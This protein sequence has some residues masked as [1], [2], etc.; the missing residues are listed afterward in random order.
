MRRFVFAFLSLLTM[1]GISSGAAFAQTGNPHFIRSQTTASISGDTLTVRFREAGLPSGSVETITVS[2]TATTTYQCV[3]RGGK[4]PSASNKTTTQTQV[5][6]SGQFTAD[7]SGNVTGSLKLSP[8]SAASL[9][10]SCP[11]GQNVEFVSV[12]YSNIVITDVTSG[13]SLA[14]PGTFSY[15]N[16]RAA[17]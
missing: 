3:N 12:T 4:N 8:P 6:V 16:P 15:T 10:F 14:I 13:A 17:R 1:L 5:S 11:P 9:G 7:R 2:A